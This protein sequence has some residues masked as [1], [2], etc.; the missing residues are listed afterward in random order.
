MAAAPLKGNP[1]ST[2]KLFLCPSYETVEVAGEQVNFYACSVG[3]AFQVQSIVRP[4]AAALAILFASRDKDVEVEQHKFHDFRGT[5]GSAENASLGASGDHVITRAISPQLAE[6]RQRDTERAISDLIEAFTMEKNQRVL[7]RLLMDSMRDLYPTVRQK[8]PTD[9][10]LDQFIA[11][12]DTTA[13][14][15]MLK[16][17]AKA[18]KELFSPL[19]DL[20]PKDASRILREALGEP[21]PVTNPATSAPLSASN[22]ARTG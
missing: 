6:I 8:K 21:S 22:P 13:L 1:L 4:I 7:A 9:P 17:L 10:E 3:A 18:N 12:V 11:G 20:A 5:E 15:Q 16:G 19:L 14:A 2:P